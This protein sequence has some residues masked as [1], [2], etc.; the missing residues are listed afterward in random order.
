MNL[1]GSES[2]AEPTAPAP[3]ETAITH[4]QAAVLHR[5]IARLPDTFRLPVVLCYLEGLTVHETADRLRIS[6]GTVRSRI[7][8]G[9]A[10]LREALAHR[11]PTG[12]RT[13]YAGV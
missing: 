10:A 3:D 4:D 1:P 6:H 9:R 8:R 5:E 12:D 11:A 2:A 7:A 13:R